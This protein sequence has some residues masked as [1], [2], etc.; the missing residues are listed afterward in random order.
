[1]G[2]DIFSFGLLLYRLLTGQVPFDDE[3][4]A[5]ALIRR[6]KEPAPTLRQLKPDLKVSKQAEKLVLSMLEKD[7]DKRPDSAMGIVAAI[8]KALGLKP[9]A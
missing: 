5:R 9:R 8:D 2:S 7:P 6:V 1:M 3:N 4:V